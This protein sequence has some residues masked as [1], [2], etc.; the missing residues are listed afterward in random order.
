VNPLAFV[1]RKSKGTLAL[2]MLA[3]VL[4]GA[5][6]VALIALIHAA[7]SSDRET[8]AALAGP[9]VGICLLSLG[10]RIGSQTLLIQLWQRSV[11][12]L[13][14][15]L[16]QRILDTPLRRLEQLGP[17]CLLAHLADDVPAVANALLGLPIL[18]VNA[19][20]VL[21]CLVYMAWLSP[22]LL[23][24]AV[25]FLVLGVGSYLL[26]VNRAQQRL[27]LARQQQDVL[28]KHFE[29]LTHGIKEL[30]MH[31]QRG[32]S[33]LNDELATAAAT[34]RRHNTAGRALY[35]TAASWGHLLFLALI[36]VLLFAMPPLL[37]VAPEVQSGYVLA[38]LYAIAPLEVVMTWL[39]A[40]GQARVAL[41]KI[42]QLTQSLPEKP[43]NRP[44]PRDNHRLEPGRRSKANGNG[45]IVA[46]PR[47]YADWQV[48]EWRQVT[49]S[50]RLERTDDEFQLGPLDLTLRRG[51]LVFLTGGNGSGKTTLAKV[52][53][54]L[55]PPE[56]GEIRVG[57]ARV[58]NTQRRR[59][60]QLFSTV[61]S[62]PYVFNNLSPRA[63]GNSD[64]QATEW[65]ERLEL[66]HRVSVRDGMFSSIDLSQGQR[67]RLALLISLLEDRPAY[68]FDEWAAD[69][70]PR[71][72]RIFYRELL[73][74]LRAQGKAVLV[75]SHDDRYFHVA[76]RL[77]E[78]EAG[79]IRDER[80]AR[81]ASGLEA[82]CGDARPGDIL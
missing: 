43:A 44:E 16:S 70:D 26:L 47:L 27:L 22:I 48:I 75:I 23:G 11:Y 17:P 66:D 35:A 7:L 68:L 67:K 40:M 29:G 36:G 15:F 41:K 3:G 18:T 42:E 38:I 5:A 8:T 61:F 63:D 25:A 77:L 28:M 9:F 13:Y 72:K 76:D 2:A 21:G 24:A 32:A 19:A 10:M 31:D 12:E 73:P 51:Q 62:P 1:L 65:L 20:V 30:Q 49:H 64:R 78:L 53:A 55:Y 82:T 50:Y 59:Y 81:G 34:L 69:Q 46:P 60:R 33:F 54:G 74:Q 80:R 56:S 4:S 6:S 79:Q 57:G 37:R 52:I 58:E 45:R 14:L 39:P 71:F